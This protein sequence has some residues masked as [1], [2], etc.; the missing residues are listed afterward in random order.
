MVL[1]KGRDMTKSRTAKAAFYVCSKNKGLPIL[2]DKE[3]LARYGRGIK[4]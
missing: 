1:I 4:A 3:D 2:A